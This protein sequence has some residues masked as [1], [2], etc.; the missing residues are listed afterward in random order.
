[1]N[2]LVTIPTTGFS[3]LSPA[4]KT[5]QVTVSMIMNDTITLSHFSIIQ[6]LAGLSM[7]TDEKLAKSGLLFIQ[8]VAILRVAGKLYEAAIAVHPSG[9]VTVKFDVT[10]DDV[11][12][13]FELLKLRMKHCEE[14]RDEENQTKPE[15]PR[16]NPDTY[17][18]Q[19]LLLL[20]LR[21]W[22]ALEAVHVPAAPYRAKSPSHS[23]E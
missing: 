6:L 10:R 7:V 1:M 13:M 9:E 22:L 14:Q 11:K 12:V 20:D 4:S 2:Q 18:G 17:I 3:S 19:K 15:N 5:E 16:F 8:P 23:E 21:E